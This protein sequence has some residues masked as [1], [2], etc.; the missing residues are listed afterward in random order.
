MQKNNN[1]KENRLLKKSLLAVSISSA[2]S[3][4]L[5]AQAQDQIEEITVTGSRIRVTQGMA[6]PTPVT[7]VTTEELQ[8]FNPGASTVEQMAQLPQF[9]N[10][11]SAQR[12]SGT[13][14]DAAGG[15]YL[16][17]RNLGRQR[18]L[19]LLDGSRIPPADKRG[20]VNVDMLPTGL[21]RS[22]DTITGGASAA[23]GADALGGVVN[24]ILDR[25]FEG[26][27]VSIGAG[28]AEW[29]DGDRRN[30]DVAGGFRV[31]D[32]L[33]IIGSFNAT[34]NDEIQRLALDV[35]NK[36]DWYRNYGHVTNPEWVA[37]RSGPQR[38]T[39]PCIARTDRA[40]SG[41]LW[42][43]VNDSAATSAPLTNFTL[44]GMVFTD[45]GQN[46]RPF[47]RAPFY[48]A[49]GAPGST[50]TMGGDCGN[51]EFLTEVKGSN[52]VSGREV[53]N[54]AGFIGGQY[55]FSDRFSG[56]V[57]ALAGRSE[58]RFNNNLGGMNFSGG[59]HGKVYR[60]N[61]FLPDNVA[62]AMDAAGVDVFQV[63]SVEK[64][65]NPN[66]LDYGYEES[67]V[68][69][70]WAW[71]AGFD[72]EFEN[73]WAL[74]AS[75]QS[76]ESHRNAGIYNEQRVDRTY[77]ALDAVTDPATG[78]VVCNVNLFN[79]TPAELA[80]S[81]SVQGRLASP[82][83][84]PGGTAGATTT[85]PL[86]SPVGLDGSIESCTPL[87]IM[88]LTTNT[89]A[90]REYINTPKRGDGIVEQDFAEVLLTGEAYEGWGYG[91]V[92]FA[93]GLTYR[94]QS[95]H[96]QALPTEI[97]VLGPPL[98]DPALGI[99]GI[100]G[101][102]TAGS[103][104]L[105]AR[106]TVPNV[107]G[108]YD[109][110]E[111]FGE[112]NVPIW[113]SASGAQRVGGS[114]AVR[115]SDYSNLNKELDSW[116]VG[117][118]FQ[119]MED[120]RLRFTRSG[121]I[122]EA[123]FSERFDTQST[124]LNLNDPFT[125]TTYATTQTSGGNPDLRPEKASTN[126]F[127]FVYQP[128]WVPGLSMSADW[129]DVQIRDSIGQLGPQRIVDECFAG[130]TTL[131]G[132]L[133]QDGAQIGRIF[134]VFLNVAQARVKGV[135]V[136]LTYNMEPNFFDNQTESFSI[137]ALGGYTQERSD[138]P[139]GASTP[140]HLEGYRGN[141]DINAL[142]TGSYG[143]GPWNVQLVQRYTDSVILNRVWTEGVH[144]DH[145]TIS[146]GNY[147]NGRV[148]YTQDLN[149]GGTWSVSLNVTNLFDRGPPIIAGQA[150]DANYE[151]YGR[152]YYVGF[153]ANF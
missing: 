38:L 73:G 133:R 10:T 68:F 24:Y 39:V 117:L 149:N 12:G 25:E 49:P 17:M 45:D 83:G 59:W 136:E 15:S 129:Y 85:A 152:Q 146:S 130:N 29:G 123:T 28:R 132:Q 96:D 98:N 48:A 112:V 5:A 40:A 127:G 111:W 75:W 7:A 81:P 58:S 55:Q 20:S 63:W 143:I 86:A 36:T 57:Q 41:M 108:G 101:G 72:Y 32:R 54:R 62:Q 27:K 141:P 88:G 76:G 142:V 106:S 148:R 124:G 23:Y 147:T 21:M 90:A 31:S 56:F 120:L 51:P 42:S 35:M 118:E 153:N 93:A 151:I 126:V 97:D 30:I 134:N 125:N 113:E 2:I 99:R 139:F 95:F 16:N 33:N 119:V 34:E 52:A 44:N 128:S 18:T 100:P 37:T 87:N 91:P 77:M 8:S 26:L 105:H 70:T 14:F 6:E 64:P 61:P 140:T 145:N 84:V 89:I 92:N 114:A 122:R 67:G 94:E 60:E 79:P 4:S 121:D 135:D 71:S 102:Y 115:Q 53:V 43:R 9:F 131:C 50:T 150:V 138:T 80:A 66:N 69:G 137:R 116:K 103:A 107:I 110:W 11:F 47:V 144:V 1:A 78:A 104:N 3:C 19:I 82:G 109:V 13:L 22:V 46:V 74:R 65:A